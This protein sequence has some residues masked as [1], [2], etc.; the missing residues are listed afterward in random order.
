MKVSE[1]TNISELELIQPE[2]KDKEISTGYTSDLLSDVMGNAPESCA[3]ITIQ[4]HK[5]SVAV[6]TLV[7]AAVIILCNNCNPEPQMVELAKEEALP[8]YKTSSNQYQVSVL[9]SKVL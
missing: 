9:L 5:N 7:G 8:I 3:L 1:L 6:A 4:G 2:F